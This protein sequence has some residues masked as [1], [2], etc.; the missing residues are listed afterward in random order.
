MIKS[1]KTILCAVIGGMLIASSCNQGNKTVVPD[2]PKAPVLAMPAF[3]AD[4][5][6]AFLKKQT[7]FGPRVP[8][9]AAHKATREYLVQQ[10]R[11]FCDTVVEQFF[12]VKTYDGK[13]QH[14]CNIIGIF[15]K[16]SQNRVL[17]SAHWDSRP[18]ADQDS[19]PT[20][21][22]EPID[23]ANDGASGVAVLLEVAR[24]L[25]QKNADQGVDIIFFDVE[26]YGT[27]AGENIEGDWW[28]LGAQHWAHH[29]HT[30]NYSAQF[31]ILL[32]MVGGP[33]VQFYQEGVSSRYAQDIVSKVWGRAYALGFGNQFI[34]TPGHPI[35]DDHYYINTIAKIKTIDIIHQDL[36]GNTGFYRTWHTTEDNIN[37]IDKNSLAVVGKVLLS[38]IYDHEL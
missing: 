17:L 12:D 7:D 8:N 34:N 14:A 9:S 5:A 27:P 22:K 3:E 11:R 1:Y 24:Q 18:F 19:D 26:D 29:P 20:R 28:C 16:N 13:T 36:S 33:G 23:G 10:L 2:T 37:N 21:R 4:S 15:N 38:I 31:G 35:T 6:F 32:D 30:P 25:H